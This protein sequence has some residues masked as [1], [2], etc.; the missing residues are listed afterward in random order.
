M[1]PGN[2]TFQRRK[3]IMKDPQITQNIRIW[4]VTGVTRRSTV[5]LIVGVERRNNQILMSLNWLEGMKK[6]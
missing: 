1:I 2:F 3:V 4:C 5:E 6:V